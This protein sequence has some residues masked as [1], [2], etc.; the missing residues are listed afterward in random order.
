[1]D[2]F[3]KNITTND[4]KFRFVNHILNWCRE[5][6]IAPKKS[7]CGYEEKIY[8]FKTAEGY[9]EFRFTEKDFGSE[10]AGFRWEQAVGGHGVYQIRNSLTIKKTAG[11]A[12]EMAALEARLENINHIGGFLRN[13]AYAATRNKENFIG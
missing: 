9:V 13:A 10:P 1:M 11:S 5:Q 12:K 3:M 6:R 4:E 2:E 8:R 7:F